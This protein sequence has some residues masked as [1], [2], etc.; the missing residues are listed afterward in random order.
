MHTKLQ[1]VAGELQ[2]DRMRVGSKLRHPDK[3][4][5][6]GHLLPERSKPPMRHKFATVTQNSIAIGV[7]GRQ[8][9]QQDCEGGQAHSWLSCFGVHHCKAPLP[10]PVERGHKRQCMHRTFAEPCNHRQCNIPLMKGHTAKNCPFVWH[11]S[12]VNRPLNQVQLPMPETRQ[13]CIRNCSL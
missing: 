9:S 1:A 7:T 10:S 6:L 3:S 13:Y 8:A 12:C 5:H 2:R 11:A 4:G